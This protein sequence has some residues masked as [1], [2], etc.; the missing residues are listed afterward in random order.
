MNIIFNFLYS[1]LFVSLPYPE[2]DFS[3]QTVIVTGSNT[4]LGLEC[5]RH[6]VR[7]NAAR[8]ILAVRTVSKGEAAAADIIASTGNPKAKSRIEVW[9]LDLASYDSIKA[10]VARVSTTLDRLDAAVLNAGILTYNFE[11]VND[12]ESQIAINSVSTVLLGLLLLPKLRKSAA[13]YGLQ[14][15][16][17]F[18]GSDVMYFAR[19]NERHASGSLWDA[20]RSEENVDMN[21]RYNVSKVLEAYS[22]RHIAAKSPVSPESNVLINFVTPGACKSDLFRD[23]MSWVQWIGMSVVLGVLARTAEQGSRTLV[24]GVQ[25]DLAEDTHGRFLLDCKVAAN[26]P[27]VDGEM[28]EKMQKKWTGELW[29]KLEQISPGVTDI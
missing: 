9:A 28:G 8:V 13:E 7:L 10:F 29:E 15:R 18:V 11:L 24:H 26:G 2:S 12:Q 4:G 5:A 25:P 6:L 21:D 19:F 22:V 20:L 17:S 16:L 23:D 3:G 27:N 1:Q 14:G